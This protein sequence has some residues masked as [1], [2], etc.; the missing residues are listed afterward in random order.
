VPDDE[1]DYEEGVNDSKLTRLFRL[2]DRAALRIAGTDRVTWFNGVVT[3]DVAKMKAGDA[4]Y[5]LAVTQKGRIL[6]DF[7]VIYLQDTL[8]AALPASELES[9]HQ[10]FE[11][12]LV[13]ED[14]EL[15]PQP[16]SAVWQVVGPSAGLLLE[17]ARAKKGA[18]GLVGE[19][20][21]VIVA[22]EAAAA[23]VEAALTAALASVGGF[24]V[25]E[26]GREIFR[27]ELAVPRFGLDFDLTTYPQEAGLEKRAVAFDKGCYLGQE[28]VCMLELRGHVK[29]KLVSLAVEGADAPK[30]GDAVLNSAGEK[31]GEVT[32]A[33]VSPTLGVLALAMVKAAHAEVGTELT[34]VG[35]KANVRDVVV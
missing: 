32:S 23:D 22:E 11:K 7:Y 19:D 35:A 28:V 8:I 12:Y 13:M 15:T 17:T 14:C 10:A 1:G 18:G 29:R 21:A 31:I 25:D 27:Q 9:V 34:V 3:C 30:R 33:S 20:M 5:G 2:S 4:R 26:A 24:L 6:A 16:T